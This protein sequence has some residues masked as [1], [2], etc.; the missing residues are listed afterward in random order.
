MSSTEEALIKNNVFG[1]INL[2][3]NL[4]SSVGGY[5]RKLIWVLRRNINEIIF[6]C[7]CIHF[8]DSKYLWESSFEYVRALRKIRISFEHN[9]F[10][11]SLWTSENLKID[12]KLY[13][14]L[15]CVV[16]IICSCWK[17]ES[18]KD[19]SIWVLYVCPRQAHFR[20][21]A[22]ISIRWYESRFEISTR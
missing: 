12:S 1:F 13:S 15:L 14:E 2:E 16:F 19:D 20:K 11:S 17:I 6:F 7:I 10:V 21:L 5:L 9:V 22:D 4:L 3:Q 18:V 8:G